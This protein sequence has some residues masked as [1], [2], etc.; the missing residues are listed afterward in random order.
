MNGRSADELS[1]G[2]EALRAV[3]TGVASAD[4]SRGLALLLAQGPPAWIQACKPLPPVAPRAAGQGPL[5]G[6]LGAEVVHLL[7]EM[8]LGRHAA[9]VAS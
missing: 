3:A 8:A 1:A 9:S 2:Y 4:G 7:T 5:P 6:R